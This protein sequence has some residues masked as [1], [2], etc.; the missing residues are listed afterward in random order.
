V[1]NLIGVQVLQLNLV[2]MQQPPE[3]SVGGAASPCS[4]KGMKEMT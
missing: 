4:W 2:I 3:E 1:L